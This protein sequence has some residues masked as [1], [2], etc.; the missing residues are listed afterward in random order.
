MTIDRRHLLLAAPAG[1]LAGCSRKPASTAPRGSLQ[2]ILDMTDAPALGGA[3]VTPEGLTFLEAAGLRNRGRPDKVTKDDLWHLGSNTK[4][5]TAALYGRLVEEGLAKWG[6]TLPELFPDLKLDP[7]WSRTSIEQV[8]SHRAGVSDGPVINTGWLLKAQSDKAPMTAQRTAL[9]STALTVPPAGRPG[10]FEYAN[11]NYILAGAAIER[12][13]GEPWETAITERLFKPLGMA[14]AGFGAPRGAQPWGH[15]RLPMG[16]GGLI[17]MDPEGAADNPAAMGPAGTVHASLTD[18]AKFVRL[19][20]TDGGGYLKPETI[21]H[22]TTPPPGADYALGWGVAADKPWAKGPRLGHEGSNTM[23]HAV[24]IVAPARGVA[25]IA[26]SNAFPSGE[27]GA[28]R[29]LVD[30]LQQRFVPA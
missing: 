20:L 26:V 2:R 15:R 4:A 18:Y 16:V 12:I 29:T 14:T 1:L 28:A 8:M 23:W 27:V 10:Q 6:A 25:I 22:L 3:V 7:A 17:P 21:A 24:A 5:M 13:V 11:L 30:Q 19:F 9:A